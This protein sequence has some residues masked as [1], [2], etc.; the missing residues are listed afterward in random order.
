MRRVALDTASRYT[1]TDFRRSF[2][3]ELNDAL[4]GAG[5]MAAVAQKAR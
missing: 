3:A 2:R 1:W 5:A 4:S